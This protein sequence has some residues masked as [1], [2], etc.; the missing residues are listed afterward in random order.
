[1]MRQSWAKTLLKAI[2]K[3]ILGSIAPYLGG[4]GRLPKMN[5]RILAERV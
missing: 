4:M 5:I 1:M 3:V 2:L